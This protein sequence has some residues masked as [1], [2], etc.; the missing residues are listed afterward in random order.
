MNS[1]DEA[2]KEMKS[3]INKVYKAMDSGQSFVFYSVQP[4]VGRHTILKRL[5]Q[6]HDLPYNWRILLNANIEK[7][8]F[9]WMSFRSKANP[10]FRLT[11][12]DIKLKEVNKRLPYMKFI[13]IK[14]SYR[15]TYY[16][17]MECM[18]KHNPC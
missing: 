15:L 8:V 2:I 5:D 12:S 7:E 4:T 14:S 1:R 6:K 13:E 17:V 10:I 18:G 11:C 3:V 9:K 16:E